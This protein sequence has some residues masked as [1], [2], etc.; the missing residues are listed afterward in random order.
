MSK[1]IL[2]TGASSGIGLALCKLLIKDH[3]CYVYLGS[4]NLA[5]GKLL[6][7]IFSHLVKVSSSI[8]ILGE[9]AKKSIIDQVPTKSDNIEVLQ[10]DV[11]DY[12]S[13]LAAAK[14]LRD[15][16]VKLYGLVNNAGIG[17]ATGNDTE[18]MMNTNYHGP[19][20]VTNAFIDLIDPKVG[21]IVNTSSGAASGWLK[22]QVK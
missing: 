19:K 14:V 9:A 20:R 15:R 17:F 18:T 1:H 10:I 22:N 6:L 5:K 8:K 11:G 7:T 2:V 13:V 3:D 4:R 21:R 12:G 16:N